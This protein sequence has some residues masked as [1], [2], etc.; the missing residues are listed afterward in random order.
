VIQGPAG[1][2]RRSLS[3]PARLSS[4]LS[5]CSSVPVAPLYLAV[6][7]LDR[8]RAENG[9][10]WL[11]QATVHGVLGPWRAPPAAAHAAAVVDILYDIPY[12]SL[13]TILYMSFYYKKDIIF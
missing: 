6:A 2:S 13:D 12:L 7:E 1:S 5:S 3:T 10:A 11:L 8:L 4:E 9:I